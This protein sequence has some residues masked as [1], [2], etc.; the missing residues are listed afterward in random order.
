ML[1]RK[2]SF[3]EWSHQE[4]IETLGITQAARKK[5]QALSMHASLMDIAYLLGGV[6]DLRGVD[7]KRNIT[8]MAGHVFGAKGIELEFQKITA[9]LVGKSGRGYSEGYNSIQPIKYCLCTLFLLNRSPCLEDLSLNV[10]QMATTPP[11]A[12]P[13]AHVRRIQIALQELGLMTFREEQPVPSSMFIS[14]LDTHDVHSV[15]LEWC[16]AWFNH[17]MELP[18][19]RRRRYLDTL[20]MVGRLAHGKPSRDCCP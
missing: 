5:Y 17:A 7:E 12:L 1:R 18:L 8:E 16:G 14:R 2:T 10:L 19:K 4:W 11:Y 20:L 9:I 3:W 6:S 13:A 15:W